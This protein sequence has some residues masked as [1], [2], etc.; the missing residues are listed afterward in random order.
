MSPRIS[1]IIFSTFL[2]LLLAV[3]D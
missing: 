3:E 2:F 1:G